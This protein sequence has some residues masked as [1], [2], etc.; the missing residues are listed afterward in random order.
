MKRN[1]TMNDPLKNSDTDRLTPIR[2]KAMLLLGQREHSRSELKQKLTRYAFEM[3]LIE[4]ILTQLQADDLLSEER[5]IESFL[6]SRIA[7]GY[8]PLRIQQEL[9]QRGITDYSIEMN[10]EVWIE[11]ACHVRQK[12]FGQGFPR[13]LHEKAK[14]MRF[15][16]YRGFNSAQIKMAL[17]DQ[18]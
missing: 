14:Q 16:Q 11:R 2:Q 3:P 15:L 8:G 12:R 4:Q 6:R 17:H 10:D 7:K 5:F 1:I 13:D 9:R 18:S